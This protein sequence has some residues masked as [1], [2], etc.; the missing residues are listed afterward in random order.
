MKSIQVAISALTLL[1]VPLLNGAPAAAEVTYASQCLSRTYAAKGIGLSGAR[2]NWSKLVKAEEGALWSDIS[3]ANNYMYV[4]EQN[5][6]IKRCKVRAI[7]CHSR[8]ILMP[9]H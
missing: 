2:K 4:C 1:A 5:E 3:A 6:K 7:P 9:M 8:L